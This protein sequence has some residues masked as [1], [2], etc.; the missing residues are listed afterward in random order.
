MKVLLHSRLRIDRADPARRRFCCQPVGNW[1]MGGNSREVEQERRH[2]RLGQRTLEAA[3]MSR[4]NTVANKTSPRLLCL[5]QALVEGK[6]DNAM[7]RPEELI[8]AASHVG[9]HLVAHA[10]GALPHSVAIVRPQDRL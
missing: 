3:V 1:T 9:Q 10:I 6:G 5:K 8:K 4:P 7:L 2:A